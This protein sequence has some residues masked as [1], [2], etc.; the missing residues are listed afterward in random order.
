VH[1]RN[2]VVA[3]NAPINNRFALHTKQAPYRT[4]AMALKLPRNALEDAL[5]WDTLDPYHY[6]RLHPISKT[7]QV[8]IVGGEDHKTGESDDGER[9]FKR[10]EAW[11]R[12]LVPEAGAVTHKWS[13]QIM[14]TIDYCGFIGRNPGDSRIY[15]ATGDSGQGM[16]HGAAAGL[17]IAGAIAG[18]QPKWAAVY[19]PSRKPVAGIGSFI[20]ENITVVKNFA[21][22]VAPGEVNNFEKLKRGQGAI[23]RQGLAKVAA[24][25]DRSGKLH[26]RSAACSHLGCHVHWNSLEECWDCPCHGSH[27]GVDGTALNGPAISSLAEVQ[28]PS[29]TGK[30]R[31]G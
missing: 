13:G 4:Y 9:R 6:V 21:E 15:V 7:Q 8:L 3:T 29:V 10:L 18:Q 1:A 30:A 2:A 19:K 12:R 28:A 23:V 17:L 11:I 25:R 27:F 14:D 26:L 20:A 24:F 16:T 31:R 22:Y 5:Y